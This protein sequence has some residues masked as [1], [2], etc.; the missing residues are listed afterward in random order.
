MGMDESLCALQFALGIYSAPE[1]R[2][3]KSANQEWVQSKFS[4]VQAGISAGLIANFSITDDFF[5]GLSF[6]YTGLRSGEQEF[7]RSRYN[8]GIEDWRVRYQA[9]VRADLGEVG[10]LVGLTF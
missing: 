5:V 10:I 8:R 1:M 4:A 7:V 9:P 2:G 3:T 6:L